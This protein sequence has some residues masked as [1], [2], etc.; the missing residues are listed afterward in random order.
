MKEKLQKY[1]LIAEII[2]AIAIV[3]S[4][5][6]VGIQIQQS[7]NLARAV[8]Y[9]VPSSDLNALNASFAAMPVFL[10][11]FRKVVAGDLRSDLD[12]DE[13]LVVGLYLSSVSNIY[14]QLLREIREGVLNADAINNFSA[15]NIFESPYYRSA[16]PYIK[17]NLSPD[18]IMELE[19]LFNLNSLDGSENISTPNNK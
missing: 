18:V 13:R 15:R 5:I 1:A 6:F 17:P 3:V 12:E 2:S 11:G 7:N 19:R 14:A 9:R 10:S 8:A 16:W 4:L